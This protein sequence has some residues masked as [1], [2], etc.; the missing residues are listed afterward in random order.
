MTRVASPPPTIRVRGRSF[1]A[2]LLAPEPP[3]D[4]WLVAL[5]AQIA[6]SPAFFEGKPVV[7]D[8][9]GLPRE[10]PGLAPLIGELRRRNIRLI[11][12][13]GAAANWG[14]AETAGL[15][16]LAG[17]GQGIALAPVSTPAKPPPEPEP[18]SLLIDSPV[19]SG[20]T[21]AFP[22]GDVIIVGSVAS[23]AEVIAGG[24]IHVYGTLRGRAV[25]GSAGNAKARI[26]CRK[27][28]AELIAIDGLYR[29]ADD[30]DRA[31][32]GR[33]VQAWLAGEVM[34]MAVLD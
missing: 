5:D 22:E 2:V 14:V 11:G 1:M 27:M 19:R 33:A 31:L 24:S 12:T 30:M 18:R 17:A 8:L 28:E 7:L 3:L 29:T 4:A 15:P 25:A 16:A 21:V 26:F 34:M 32:R 13:E 23:G 20:Q 10:N 9:T 6:R